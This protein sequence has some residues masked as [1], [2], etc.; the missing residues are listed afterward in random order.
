MGGEQAERA[1]AVEA[2]RAFRAANAAMAEQYNAV[3]RRWWNAIAADLMQYS[4]RS[5]AEAEI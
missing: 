5:A 2:S 4:R 3:D 1:T